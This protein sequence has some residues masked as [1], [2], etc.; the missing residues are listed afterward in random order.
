MPQFDLMNLVLKWASHGPGTQLDTVALVP[1]RGTPDTGDCGLYSM[2][3][4]NLVILFPIW[5]CMALVPLVLTQASLSDGPN[6]P[7][8]GYCIP[9]QGLK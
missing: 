5:A 7:H 9:H 3:H 8:P 6:D 2:P 4:Q 1:T